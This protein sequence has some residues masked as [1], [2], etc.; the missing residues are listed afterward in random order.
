MDRLPASCAPR[1]GSG[2]RVGPYRQW[3]RAAHGRLAL[4]FACLALATRLKSVVASAP[5]W[6]PAAP[7]RK[8]K[9]GRRCVAGR[10]PFAARRGR[11]GAS[12]ARLRRQPPAANLGRGQVERQP[13]QERVRDQL[14][15]EERGR[16]RRHAWDAPRGQQA[17]A[18]RLRA[19]R[20]QRRGALG[21]SRAGLEQGGA[22]TGM[23]HSAFRSPT[24]PSRPGGAPAARR[25]R[26]GGV[27]EARGAPGGRGWPA[28]AF[29]GGGVGGGRAR[30]A[31]ARDTR[32]TSTRHSWLPTPTTRRRVRRAAA[33]A[34]STASCA[35]AGTTTWP[36]EGHGRV[37]STASPRTRRRHNPWPQAPP[38]AR[39]EHAAAPGLAEAVCVHR[40]LPKTLLQRPTRRDVLPATAR[41]QPVPAARARARALPRPPATAQGRARAVPGGE[42]TH[43]R[44]GG[45]GADLLA[46]ARGGGAQQRRGRCLGQQAAQARQQPRRRGRQQLRV[47]R[48]VLAWRACALALLARGGSRSHSRRALAH[49]HRAH[50]GPRNF[51]TRSLGVSGC[52]WCEHT[53]CRG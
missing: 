41:S 12:G 27:T 14:A 45:R 16:E 7:R 40:F 44:G 11:A 29:W 18:A 32:G 13:V 34:S 43:R 31:R 37:R 28:G 24:R 2:L 5:R 52:D 9:R 39:A 22:C 25:R 35:R 23:L 48:V 19:A 47:R 3:G 1:V 26:A 49:A 46:R 33:S 15:E 4:Q 20:A 8:S 53:S 10:W 6:A 50:R 30:S 42:G 38:A 51:M 17:D 36:A 21:C